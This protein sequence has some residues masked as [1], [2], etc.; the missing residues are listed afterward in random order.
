MQLNYVEL[1]KKNDKCFVIVNE[2][3]DILIVILPVTCV[4]RVMGLCCMM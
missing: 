4:E 2:Q 1:E 3:P